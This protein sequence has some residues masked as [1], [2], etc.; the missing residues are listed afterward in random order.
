MQDPAGPI[1]GTVRE[2]TLETVS[3]TV[4]QQNY[5]PPGP[6]PLPDGAS[7]VSTTSVDVAKV[8]D[9]P[10]LAAP[11]RVGAVVFRAGVPW[12]L[13]IDAAQRAYEREELHAPAPPAV[14]A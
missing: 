9:E 6:L 3:G 1:A 5:F 10:R 11:A 8:A 2:S 7:G 12:A 13:V 14:E 4:P